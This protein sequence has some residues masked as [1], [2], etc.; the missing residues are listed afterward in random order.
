M[1]YT[2]LIEY[3]TMLGVRDRGTINSYVMRRI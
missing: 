2:Y 3:H 1:S